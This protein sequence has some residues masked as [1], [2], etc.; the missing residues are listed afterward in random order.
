MKNSEWRGKRKRDLKRNCSV[1]S[2]TSCWKGT[3]LSEGIETWGKIQWQ[4]MM[5]NLSIYM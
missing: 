1:E 5:P 3:E 4:V 2:R